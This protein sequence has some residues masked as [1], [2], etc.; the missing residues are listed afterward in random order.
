MVNTFNVLLDPWQV[1][2]D[3]GVGSVVFA[4]FNYKA[5]YT[6]YSPRAV[7]ISAHKWTP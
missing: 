5:G 6:V 7:I 1:L 3:G 4:Q 2:V